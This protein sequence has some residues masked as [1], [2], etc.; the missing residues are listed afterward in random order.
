MDAK[1]PEMENKVRV[2]LVDDQSM[3]ARAVEKMLAGEPDIEFSYCQD[4]IKAIPQALSFQPTV[5]LQD[6]V[7]PEIDGL[8]LVRFFRKNA[9]TK[10]LPL[11]V[12]SSKEEPVTKA[13]AFSVGANDYLVKL[14]DRIELLARLRYHSRGY[15]AMLERN[16]AIE[17]LYEEL[18]EAAK[19]VE[20][21]LPQPVSQG[22]VTADWRYIPSTS[23]GGDAFGYHTLPDGKL[24]VFLLD[25]SGHGVG[26]A[27]LSVSVMNVLRSQSLPATDFSDPA[28]VLA[29][30]NEAFAMEKQNGMFFTIWY[31]VYDSASRTLSF[32]GGGH[33]P[34]LLLSPGAP[35][36]RLFTRNLA[37]GAMPDIPFRKA[38]VTIPADSTLFIYS[39]GVYEVTRRDGS[40]WPLDQFVAFMEERGRDAS[41]NPMDALLAHAKGLSATGALDDDFSIVEMKMQ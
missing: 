18:A 19:Y 20:R 2:L 34:A 27:L 21:L 9:K 29:G 14:P 4:P 3:V 36:Q 23:L 30:L 17:A 15:T 26:A 28:Q 16:R 25:V 11:I 41:P 6:L 12:L 7:M 8:T 39:D 35:V 22:P 1:T 40:V 24:A 33:P 37:I 32:A 38:S 31:G 5:V 13:E 10:D